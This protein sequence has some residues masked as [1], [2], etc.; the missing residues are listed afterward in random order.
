MEELQEFH[1]LL[2]K[3]PEVFEN[4]REKN[5]T[6]KYELQNVNIFRRVIRLGEMKN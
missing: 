1:R 6:I 2:L 5:K 4:E 3:R